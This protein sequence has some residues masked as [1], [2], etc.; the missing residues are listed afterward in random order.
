[1]DWRSHQNRKRSCRLF[2]SLP[3]PFSVLPAFSRDLEQISPANIWLKTAKLYLS[4]S[5]TVVWVCARPL[6][7]HFLNQILAY[8]DIFK[9]HKWTRYIVTSLMGEVKDVGLNLSSID[10]YRQYIFC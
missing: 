5:L 2:T 4:T 8:L 6:H 7:L 10:V 9:P 1:M 3:M